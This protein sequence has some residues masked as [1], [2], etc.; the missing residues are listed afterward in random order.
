MNKK[1]QQQGGM[2][3]FAKF[4]I[5]LILV[6]LILGALWYWKVITFNKI[7]IPNFGKGSSYNQN[8]VKLNIVTPPLDKDWCKVQTMPIGSFEATSN[9]ILGWDDRNDC[10]LQEIIGNDLCTNTEGKLLF[11]YNSNVGGNILWSAYNGYYFANVMDY[12]AFNTMLM[13]SS[14]LPDSCMNLNYPRGE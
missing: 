2:G 3:F 5:F 7:P 6:A 10:C 9:K 12:K 4:L 11:C 1:A 14:Q 13:Q 8:Q